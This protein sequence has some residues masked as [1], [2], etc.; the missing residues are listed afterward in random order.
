V[1]VRNG[2]SHGGVNIYY[3]PIINTGN[4]VPNWSEIPQQIK[5]TGT[6]FDGDGTKF[7]DYRDNYVIPQQGE[8]QIVFP[9]QN[10]FN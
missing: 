3:D 6:I 7:Y 8:Q 5:T 1:F 9:R 2:T 10:V 4:L